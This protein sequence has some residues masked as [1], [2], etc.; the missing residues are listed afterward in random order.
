MLRGVAQQTHDGVD[1]RFKAAKC[2][3]AGGHEKVPSGF[4]GQEGGRAAGGGVGRSLVLK[5]GQ[6]LGDA[7]TFHRWEYSGR[8]SGGSG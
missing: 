6:K 5:A 4:G 2:K 8:R 7:C 1:Q 3:D